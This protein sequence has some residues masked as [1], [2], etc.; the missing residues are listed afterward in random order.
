MP[1]IFLIGYFVVILLTA[2]LFS[3]RIQNLRDFFLAGRSLGSLSVA[4]TLTASW[5]GAAST[6]GSINA[7]HDKG[8]SGAWELVIP[9]VLSFVAITLFMAKPVARQ[10][11]LSQPEAVEAYYGKVGRLL[12]S[13]IILAATTVLIGSQMVAAGQV[14]RTVFGLDI[15]WSTIVCTAAVVSYSLWGGYF[16]VVV[17]DIAQVIFIVIGF[18]ILLAFTAGQVLPDA[19]AWHGFLTQQPPHF[20]D[21]TTHLQEHI[22]MVITFVLAWTIAPEMWQRMSSTRNPDLAFRAGWQAALIM[23]G[24]FSMIILIGLLSTKLIGPHPA[25]LVALALKIPNQFLSALVLLGFVAAVTS[26]MDSSLNVGSLTLTRDIYQGFLNPNA[27]DRAC[28]RVSRITTALIVLPAMALALYFQD[29]IKILWI[30]AD[31]YASCMFFPVVGM[32]YIPNPGRW[33][34]VLAMIFGGITVCIS[35]L[36]Q[37]GLVPDVF[38]WPNWPYSTLLGIGTSG[39]GYA[40]GYI[41]SN[42]TTVSQTPEERPIPDAQFEQS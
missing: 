27:S 30:S 1:L 31:I 18:L 24:L 11:Y 19:A 4:L 2:R 21:F 35:A 3:R 37:N 7:F 12:L 5:F 15:T 13:V 22:F 33:S 6:M 10:N 38:H 32:L 14:F 20:W 26:T 25:V 16:T 9:S 23:A 28:I 34:G 36:I 29:I 42:R 40:I 8:I 17:T 41:I 39:I